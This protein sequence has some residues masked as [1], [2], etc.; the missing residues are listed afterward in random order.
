MIKKIIS[1]ILLLVS[2]LCGA[3]AQ[4]VLRYGPD[5]DWGW[6]AASAVIT[7][8]VSFPRTMVKPYAGCTITRVRIGVQQEGTNVYL[9]IKNNPKDTRY[10]YRQK[11]SNLEP[12]WNE[13]TLDQPFAVNGSDDIAIGYKASFAKGGG[14][15]CSNEK[16]DDGNIIYYNSQNKWTTTNGSVCIQA[17][18]EGDAIPAGEMMI[19]RLYDYVAGYDEQTATF[20]STVRNVG[21]TD[22]HSY[23][24][25]YT[26]DTE[27]HLLKMDRSVKVNATDTF[28]VTVPATAVGSHTLTLTIQDVNGVP[29]SYEANN[30]VSARLTVRDSTFKRRIVCEEYTGTWC[31]WCPHGLVGLELM[32]EAHPDLFIP[33][34]VHGGDPMEID[35]GESYSYKPFIDSCPGAPM[36]NVSRKLTG[37]PYSD[38]NRMF[39]IESATDSHIAY[40][41]SGVWNADSTAIEVTSTYFSDRDIANAGY[42]IAYTVTEDSITGYKQTNYYAGGK[43][44]TMYGWEKKTDP[45]DDVWF[46]DVARAIYPSYKG[47]PCRQQQ[48]AAGVRYSETFTV[49]VPPDVNNKRQIAVTGQIIDP[50]SGY[51]VNAMRIRP[52]TGSVNAVTTISD[53]DL[54]IACLNRAGR[55]TLSV[56]GLHE[57]DAATAMVCNTAGQLIASMPVSNGLNEFAVKSPGLYLISIYKGTRLIR[58]Y[59]IAI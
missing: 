55:I 31:G 10:I 12:G 42:N 59:K 16:W 17:I 24:I 56:T 32:K 7:P 8:Y 40:S 44:G 43:N 9:Y 51:I 38:I 15:G 27:E 53:N 52:A 30:S 46:N 35:A 21:S 25:K 58:T 26:F 1:L 37:D 34:S 20:S 47:T 36:C 41:L 23:T 54:H 50:G 5:I 2:A 28:S 19:G 29:D 3:T 49:P 6:G 4:V 14:V 22:V 45:T 57:Q 33:I 39:G 13:I 18:V 48:L 11:L